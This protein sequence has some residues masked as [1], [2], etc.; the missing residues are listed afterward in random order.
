MSRIWIGGKGGEREPQ[1]GY[2]I[3]KVKNAQ[4]SLHCEESCNLGFEGLILGCERRLIG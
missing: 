2:S 1:E 4:S 3:R